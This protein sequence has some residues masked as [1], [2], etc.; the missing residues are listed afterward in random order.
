MKQTRL[1]RS[2]W[3][4]GLLL[5]LTPGCK[6]EADTATPTPAVTPTPVVETACQLNRIDRSSGEYELYDSDANGRTTKYSLFHADEKGKIPTTPV[7]GTLTYN[8]QG[9][10]ERVTVAADN[11]HKQFGYTNG[12]LSKIEIF[13]Q[14]KKM[15]QYDVTT[16]ANKHITAMK[17]ISFTKDPNSVYSWEYSTTFTL[18]A[19]GRYT[20][21]TAKGADGDYYR[22]IRTGFEPTMKSFFDT[23]KD[24][25]LPVDVTNPSAEYG[26]YM[27]TAPGQR[28]KAEYFWGYDANDNYVGLK[29]DREFTFS[30][31]ANSR[32]YVTER[33]STNV[34]SKTTSTTKFQ[35]SN[36][37]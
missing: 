23:W 9:L 1:F 19:Q 35:Y 29:K 28:L 36:C 6:K 24:N 21:L 4:V 20:S 32:N 14:N 17:G 12:A 30:P 13:E 37:N 31:K 22:E 26:L 8:A 33:T 7:V 16:N 25:G 3:A 34:L 27:P 10:A 2:L 5:T 11:Y 18:D 15:Y